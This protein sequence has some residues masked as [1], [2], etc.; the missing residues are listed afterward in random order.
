MSQ[1]L[2]VADLFLLSPGLEVHLAGLR[3][4][5]MEG[6]MSLVLYFVAVILLNQALPTN[7]I[8]AGTVATSCILVW[9]ILI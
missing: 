7:L 4:L 2:T 3:V 9:R 5:L 8:I 6:E 1:R